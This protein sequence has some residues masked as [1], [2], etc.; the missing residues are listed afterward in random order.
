MPESCILCHGPSPRLKLYASDLL[1]QSQDIYPI[2]ECRGCGL[3]CTSLPGNHPPPRYPE[4]YYHQLAVHGGTRATPPGGLFAERLKSLNRFKVGGRI[5]DVGCGDGG[6]LSALKRAGWEAFGTEIDDAI[7]HALRRQ[8][9]EIY[10]GKLPELQLP[11]GSFDAITY[12]GSFEHV[13][14]PLDELE[15]AKRILRKDGLLLLNLTNADSLEARIFGPRWMGYEAPRHRFNY[16]AQTFRLMVTSKGFQLLTMD[17]RND[18]FIT[19][20]SLVYGLGLRSRYSTVEKPLRWLLKPIHYIT[21]RFNQGN[22][23]EVAA[24]PV[25]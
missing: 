23:F 19:S 24:R 18:D 6:F 21:R 10:G 13:D 8:G 7:V 3:L 11:Q 14:Q 20:F 4:D 15:A 1:Y 16:T 22:V 17:I 5:L 25:A 9:L 12:F 2:F